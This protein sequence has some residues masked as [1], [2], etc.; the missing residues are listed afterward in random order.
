MS[1]KADTRTIMTRNGRLLVVEVTMSNSY[2]TGGDTV[3]V[4]GS[5]KLNRLEALILFPSAGYVPEYDD[6]NKKVK[7]FYADYPAASAGA[8]IEVPAATDLSTVKFLGLAIGR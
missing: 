1:M 4:I 3:D 5:T 2:A 6:T 8:L 7:V